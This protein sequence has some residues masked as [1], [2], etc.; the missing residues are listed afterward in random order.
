MAIW[1]LFGDGNHEI[2]TDGLVRRATPG[3]GTYVGKIFKVRP[4]NQG[5]RVVGYYFGKKYVLRKV[6]KLVA[7]A[8]MPPCPPGMEINHIDGDKMNAS[9]LN[10]EYM[11]HQGNA[12]HALETGLTKCKISE[13]TVNQIRELRSQGKL[14]REITEATGV[15]LWSIG[16]IVRGETRT[17]IWNTTPSKSEEA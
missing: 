4:G 3:R 1:K 15:N 5:Y 7:E 8:F 2:S 17:R 6:H 9:L 16:N 10:L 11:T 14:Y 13:A 12:E